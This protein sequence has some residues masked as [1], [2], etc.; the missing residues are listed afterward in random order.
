MLALPIFY[1]KPIK[2]Q[3]LFFQTF[4]ELDVTA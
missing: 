1:I 4:P 2:A 3:A